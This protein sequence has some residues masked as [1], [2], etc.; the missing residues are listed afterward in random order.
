MIEPGTSLSEKRRAILIVN[1]NAGRGGAR[2]ARE[3]ARFCKSLEARGVALETAETKKAGDAARLAARAEM[4]GWREIIV[5]GGDGTI[6]EALQ[7]L[8]RSDVRLAVWP[9]GTANVLARELC[10]PFATE[11]VAEVIA[12]GRTR[13]ISIGCA[14]QEA[15]KVR[16][17]FLLMAG[18]G[19]DA[20]VVRGTN[21]RLKRSIGEAAFW[22]SGLE[23]LARW[24]PHPFNVEIAGRTYRATFAAIGK[25][26]RYGGNLA[27]TPRARPDESCFEICLVDSDSKLR[28]LKL[29]SQAL[30][31]RGVAEHLPYVQTL[32]ATHVRITGETIV[33][34][35]GELIGTLPMTFDILPERIEII[36]P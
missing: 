14:T 25:V 23:H 4:E 33:Q 27:I 32:R 30:R 13:R 15:T 34:A 5:A 21:A 19:L 28:Y 24:Q 26:S 2:R 16:R 7:G 3:V 11:R 36:V 18:I 31:S 29:L 12:R 6:N 1:P 8:T 20:S 35:D 22:C 17:R 9:R 10:L